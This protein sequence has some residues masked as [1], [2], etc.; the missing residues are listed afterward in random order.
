MN[1]TEAAFLLAALRR[2]VERS[3]IRDVANKSGMSHGAIHNLVSGKTQRIH[4][5]TISRLRDWYLRMWAAGGDGLTSEVAAYLI[6][7]VMATVSSSSRAAA[8]LELV[9]A[10]ERIFDSHEAPRPAWLPVVRD[11]YQRG[12][13]VVG[14]S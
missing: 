6:E 14:T 9:Q 3:S 1:S 5:A 8:A 13:T 10:L 12:A 7:Q 11:E 2:E 4:G